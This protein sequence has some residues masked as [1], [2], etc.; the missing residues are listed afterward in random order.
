MND[1][2]LFFQNFDFVRHKFALILKNAL[3]FFFFFFFFF[4]WLSR[5]AKTVAKTGAKVLSSP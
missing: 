2:M 3:V 4:F 5:G 1:E